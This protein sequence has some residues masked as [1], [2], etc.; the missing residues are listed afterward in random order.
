MKKIKTTYY[1]PES[2]VYITVDE[3]HSGVSVHSDGES[4]SGI[5][6]HWGTK[7]S[8]IEEMED[9]IKALKEMKTIIR[10]AKCRNPFENHH[11]IHTIG[12]KVY[13]TGC[14]PK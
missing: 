3:E 8:L 6:K 2:Y 4:C 13:H 10:C 9:I 12:K 1:I 7:E 5:L 11:K 14:K